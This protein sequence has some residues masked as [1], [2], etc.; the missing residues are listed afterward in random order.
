MSLERK[1]SYAWPGMCSFHKG[2]QEG[3]AES[4]LCGPPLPVH[5]RKYKLPD[6]VLL[7]R[8]GGYFL[9]SHDAVSAADLHC[10]HETTLSKV[11]PG[12]HSPQGHGQLTMF[13]TLATE[14]FLMSAGKGGKLLTMLCLLGNCGF[15]PGAPICCPPV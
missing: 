7:M 12:D 10:Q 1:Q 6:S 13:G 5:H 3:L 4:S 8:K 2:S 15:T 9:I 11:P 14:V